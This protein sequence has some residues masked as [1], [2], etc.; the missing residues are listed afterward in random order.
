MHSFQYLRASDVPSAI[1]LVAQDPGAQF[2]AGGTSQVDLMKEDVQH[3]VRL[4]DI[5]QLPLAEIAPTPSG[6][7]RIGANVK[8]AVAARHPLVRTLYPAM[9]EALLSGASQQIRN[10]ASMAGNMLQR[11]RCP[12]L[13]DPN[14]P[15]NKR[16]PGT[17]CAAFDGYNRMHAIFGQS[18]HGGTSALTCIAA[19]PSD[20]TT[21]LAAHEAVIVVEGLGGTRNIAF[22]D[23]YRLPGET[24]HIDTNLRHG[25]LIV[26]IELPAFKGNSHY[27]KVRDRA[28]YAYA[29]V[30]CAV[31]LRMEGERIAA[32]RIALGS[33]AHKPWR[34]YTAEA[35]LEGQKPNRELFEEAATQALE[36]ARPY[37][38]N[39]YKLTLGRAVV[40]RT[41]L[42][43]VGLE[44][45]QGPPGTAFASSV[46][47]IAG[48]GGA[49]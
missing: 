29:L 41:L 38:M 1:A 30:S 20:L 40:Q 6:G 32:A 42:E 4:V 33:V 22:G 39:R 10:M 36:G 9:S 47:G 45:L 16:E 7:L 44:P 25:D 12:Y 28:S 23:L 48:I 11:T 43:T 35:M 15:C 46:G 24:P 8:N 14:Q 31:A 17:G 34:A 37:S 27:L 5:S 49:P 18:D 21:A 26:A 19:H 2:L 3:P 13:R